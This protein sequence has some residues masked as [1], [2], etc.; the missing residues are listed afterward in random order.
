M[1]SLGTRPDHGWRQHNVEVRCEMMAS[2]LVFMKAHYGADSR[3]Y[4]GAMVI[5]MDLMDARAISM[6]ICGVV[7]RGRR[8]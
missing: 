4:A 7:I 8:Q 1:W 3:S 6:E 5:R 2:V